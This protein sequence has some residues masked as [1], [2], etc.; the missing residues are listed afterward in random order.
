MIMNIVINDNLKN[1]G[2]ISFWYFSYIENLNSILTLGILSKNDIKRKKIPH[3][4][5]AEETVQ[6]RR[7]AKHII[8]TNKKNCTI[9]DV[10]PVYM[11]PKTPTLFA[12]KKE[13]YRLF[14]ARIQTG[15]IDDEGIAFAFTDGNAASKTTNFYSD[16]NQLP[17]IP[18][19]VLNSAY[20][21]D[22]D[23]GKRKRNSE[24]LIYPYIPI[25]RIWELGVIH[26]DICYQARAIINQHN[27]KLP[28][29][30]RREW[31]F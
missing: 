3:Y 7:Y 23:D 17:N 24:F 16:L 21:N 10:V 26:D 22:F 25:H 8:L 28:V 20:W 30:T 2:I 29:N 13:Q 27:L 4:S 6:E 9:H 18:W 14:F 15:I 12:R 31:F 11:T 5:F 19:D 1:Y